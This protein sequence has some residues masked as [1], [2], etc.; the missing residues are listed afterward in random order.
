MKKNVKHYLILFLILISTEFA[1]SQITTP[2]P[3]P[4]ATFTQQIGLADVSITY[5]RPSARGRKIFG[6]LVPFGSIWRTGANEATKIKFSDEVSI[7]GKKLPAG[8]YGLFTIP[9]QDEW[10]I[11]FSKK[12]ELWGKEG[13]QESDDAIRFTAKVQKTA[14]PVETFTINIADVTQTGANLEIAWENTLVKFQITSDVDAKVVAQIEKFTS[15]PNALL[16][17]SYYQAASYYYE[18]DKD[19]NKALEW[20]NKTLEVNQGYWVYHLKAKIQGKLKD[21]K[22]AISTAETSIAKAKEANNPD[23]VKLNEKLITEWKKGK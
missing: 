11:I 17:N 23:Y 16:A 2:Q 8:E 22:N 21:Y 10:T 4:K 6:D 3:S 18:T 19:L 15:N 13:Y 5:S 12:T 14:A 1:F 9:G 20:I 7:E